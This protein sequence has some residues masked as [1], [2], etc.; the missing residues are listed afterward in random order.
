MFLRLAAE[1]WAHL[2]PAD[3]PFV[4]QVMAQL[5]DHDDRAQFLAG[6]DFILVGIASVE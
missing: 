3:Y 5:P 6:I 1:R 2:D 4:H